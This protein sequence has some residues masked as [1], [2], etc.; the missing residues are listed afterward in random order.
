MR[1]A[2]FVRSSRNLIAAECEPGGDA[3]TQNER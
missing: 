3:K 1:D 2:N